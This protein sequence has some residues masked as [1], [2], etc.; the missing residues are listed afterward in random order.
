[1]STHDEQPAGLGS[2]DQWADALTRTLNEQRARTRQFLQRQQERFVKLNGQWAAQIH[3]SLCPPPAD[4]QATG[5]G[6]SELIERLTTE[7]EQ[8]QAALEHAESTGSE[9]A[10]QHDAL[11]AELQA[12]RSQRQQL[13]DRL[14]EAESKLADGPHT[15]AV[16]PQQ[17][18]D[19]RRRFEMAVEDVRELKAKNAELEQQR[20]SGSGAPAGPPA[21][22]PG[23]HL[24]WEAQKRRLMAQ[25]ED[26]DDDDEDDARDR[27]T[28]EGA[29]RITDQVVAEKEQQIDEL[30][31]QLDR[32]SVAPDPSQAVAETLN[33]DEVIRE[34][35]ENLRRL[36]QDWQEKLRKAEIEISVERAK[37]ARERTAMEEQI[38][39]YKAQIE[40]LS[41]A[42]SS[43][44][45]S[46]GSKTSGRGNWLA[47]LGLTGDD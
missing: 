24:D 27:L 45:A 42:D 17:Y 47:R 21:D 36:Q 2:A 44:A 25:L 30:R 3:E 28:I 1:M 6:Q 34:E 29:I 26:F 9:T 33:A 20:Q 18:D 40:Q 8:L 19:L 4:E 11:T 12:L 43:S 14:T 5:P 35:R 39:S 41:A 31:S 38:Q 13:R 23:G 7:V 22:E 15:S 37:L 16:D 46:D 32:H 10:S